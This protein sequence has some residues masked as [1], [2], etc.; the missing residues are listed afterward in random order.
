M[1]CPS[2]WVTKSPGNQLRIL[3]ISQLLVAAKEFL[4]SV[5]ADIMLGDFKFTIYFQRG[6]GEDILKLLSIQL[7][8]KTCA[9]LKSKFSG[10]FSYGVY[11]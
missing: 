10:T 4:R 7:D 1:V 2:N 5:E 11:S 8:A 6:I 9:G 3:E